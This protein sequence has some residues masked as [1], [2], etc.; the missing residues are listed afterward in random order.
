[1]ACTNPVRLQ[2]DFSISSLKATEPRKGGTELKVPVAQCKG[3]Q[4]T[5]GF[6]IPRRGFQIPGTRFWILS[7]WDLDSGFQS[8]KGFRILW[9]VFR[10]PKSRIPDSSGKNFPDSGI[11][12]FLTRGDS[13][14]FNICWMVWSSVHLHV[15]LLTS[16]YKNILATLST[17]GS[18]FQPW[19]RENWAKIQASW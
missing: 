5:F 17:T 8:L 16:T 19:H 6:W 4:D 7:Q 15:Y 11:F 1:M 13:W 9:V 18:V 3:I 10:I 2:K 14:I 12:I